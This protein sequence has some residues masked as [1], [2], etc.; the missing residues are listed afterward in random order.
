MCYTSLRHHGF[1][2]GILLRFLHRPTTPPAGSRRDQA[3]H[4]KVG[5]LRAPG[6]KRCARP[7]ELHGS[8][9]TLTEASPA[10]P[11]E[12]QGAASTEGREERYGCMG[13]HIAPGSYGM[14]VTIR[15]A[16]PPEGPIDDA[17]ARV[18][19]TSHTR[20]DE[21]GIR[22]APIRAFQRMPSACPSRPRMCVGASFDEQ[23]FRSPVRGIPLP[24][25]RH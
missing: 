22:L 17:I 19:G 14:R 15:V 5:T 2:P 8:P 13:R 21:P 10:G 20:Q 12:R 6:S 18:T 23:S 16:T 7:G 3:P 1:V 24:F 4:D 9:L 11:G 25:H